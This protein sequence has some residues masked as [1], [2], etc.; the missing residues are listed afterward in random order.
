QPG[1][2]RMDAAVMAPSGSQDSFWITV[3]G[4]PASAYLWDLP[5]TATSTYEVDSVNDR[6]GADPVVVTL[7]A[8]THTV[9]VI[10]REAGARLDWMSLVYLPPPV[11]TDG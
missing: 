1:Q 5:P 10:H 9:E 4:A 8:G 11:D 3:D 2:Y 7:A 6:N